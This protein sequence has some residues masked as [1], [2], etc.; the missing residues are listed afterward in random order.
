MSNAMHDD[1][2]LADS[3]FLILNIVSCDRAAVS[4]FVKI[5]ETFFYF[6]QLFCVMFVYG[7]FK[8]RVKCI[9]IS[10]IKK[11]CIDGI[12]A[13]YRQP[14]GTQKNSKKS[15]NAKNSFGYVPKFD[16]FTGDD[17]QMQVFLEYRGPINNPPI[18]NENQKCNVRGPYKQPY[19]FF[20]NLVKS[21][22][23][24]A[25]FFYNCGEKVYIF[26]HFFKN[27]FPKFT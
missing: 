22:I 11:T 4:I 13:I 12:E 19:F 14:F 27:F 3:A 7:I 2:L 6:Y 23:S 24:F 10:D 8:E 9:R 1:E 26:Y 15:E 5:L 17:G 18:N 20:E 21:C 16:N 25:I